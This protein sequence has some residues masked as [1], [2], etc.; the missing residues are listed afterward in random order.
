MKKKDNRIRINK[1]MM[2]WSN[3]ERVNM[4]PSVFHQ[5]DDYGSAMRKLYSDYREGDEYYYGS[6]SIVRDECRCREYEA[7]RA[8]EQGRHLEALKGM[9]SAALWVLPDESVGLEFEDVQW[10]NPQETLYWHRNV[11]EFLRY[12]RRCIGY[13]KRDPRLWPIYNGSSIERKYH[14]YLHVLG[15]WVHDGK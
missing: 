10:L 7:D 3:G 4:I 11:Q 2:A 15:Q 5:V 12:N 1:V 13:C 14:N 8:W 6:C 9:M